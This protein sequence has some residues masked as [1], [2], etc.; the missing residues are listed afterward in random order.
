[1][2]DRLLRRLSRALKKR[3]IKFYAIYEDAAK[4]CKTKDAYENIELCSMIGDKTKNYKEVLGQKPW[5]LKNTN[6]FLIAAIHDFIM[7]SSTLNI[8]VI[9]FGGAC[10]AHYFEIRRFFPDS[11]K[12]KWHVVETPEMF[13]SAKNHVFENEELLFIDN[14]EII[15]TKI[16]FIH[17]SG[18]LQSVPDYHCFLLQLMKFDAKYML[19]NRMMFNE[20]NY[21][22]VTIQKSKLSDNGPG[23]MP[24]KYMDKEIFY[25]HTTIALNNFLNIVQEKYE[26][27]WSFEENSGSYQINDEKIIGRGLL[28]KLKRS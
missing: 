28:F 11:L 20:N 5:I 18:A 12:F 6:V 27:E 13:R 16:D 2:I 15:E 24:E 3:T 17:S 22:F 14:I 7:K 4:K 26:L 9:D 25:P 8:S 19:F 21:D 10:G 23:P 1:M